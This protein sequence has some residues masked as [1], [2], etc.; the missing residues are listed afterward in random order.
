MAT[1]SNINPEHVDA[2]QVNITSKHQGNDED[3][4]KKKEEGNDEE[5]KLQS[6]P[7][8][9]SKE[10]QGNRILFHVM[11]VNNFIHVQCTD[12]VS[13]EKSTLESNQTNEIVDTNTT[14]GDG[15]DL[16]A[17]PS[18]SSNDQTIKTDTTTDTVASPSSSSTHRRQ[19][20]MLNK[21]RRL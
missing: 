10:T 19:R 16:V 9:S 21:N 20:K 14:K 2:D 5:K 13:S 18:D 17:T 3:S 15:S 8:N 12:L 6:T 4:E 1:I 7:T 11:K